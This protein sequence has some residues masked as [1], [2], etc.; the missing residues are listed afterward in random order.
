VITTDR[1]TLL[2]LG[3]FSDA[4]KLVLKILNILNGVDN[5]IYI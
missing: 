3:D 4:D 2:G 1:Y 5:P